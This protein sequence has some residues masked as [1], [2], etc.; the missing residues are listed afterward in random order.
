[1]VCEFMIT[2]SKMT[3]RFQQSEMDLEDYTKLVDQ[4]YGT[5]GS[6]MAAVG[7]S[8][9]L[10]TIAYAL[11]ADLLFVPLG[12]LL[13]TASIA[14]VAAFLAYKRNRTATPTR[15]E[16]RKWELHYAIPAIVWMFSLGVMAF[17]GITS[18]NSILH[19]F[20]TT[21]VIGTCGGMSSR[22]ASRPWIVMWQ[23]VAVLA[24]FSAGLLLNGNPYVS[25]LTAMVMFLALSIKSGT[26]YISD[27]LHEAIKNSRV[28]R[29]TAG[30]L[31]TAM[32]NMSQGLLMFDSA[33]TLV[34]HN[35]QFMEM[36]GVPL[37][38]FIDGK[39]T[40]R[41]I[42]VATCQA[43]DGGPVQPIE[44]TYAR[45]K[46]AML[47]RSP[48][49]IKI[50]RNNGFVYEFVI[51]PKDDGGCVVRVQDITEAER[52][53][54]QIAKMAH[55][56]DLTGM[57]NRALF[58]DRIEESFANLATGGAQFA[59]LS[60]DL[61]QFKEVNDTLGH[62]VGDR[63]LV[64]VA[65]RLRK[66]VRSGDFVARLGGDEFVVIQFNSSKDEAQRLAERL[67]TTICERFVLEGQDLDIGASIGIAM[68]P[69]DGGDPEQLMKSAD[70]ALYCSK[71]NGR[72]TWRFFNADM[73]T[74]L[75]ERRELEKDL[76]K[77]I[78]RDELVVFFQPIVDSKTRLVVTC[79]ALVRWKH[80]T[81]GMIFP[82]IF[83]KIAEDTGMIVDLGGIVLR[84]ACQEAMK[85]PDHVRV[86]V[87]LS[88]VQFKRNVAIDQ[89]KEALLLSGL[90]A[91]RLEVEI[92]ESML[93]DENVQQAILQLKAYGIRMSLDDFGTGYSSFQYLLDFD[94]D[95]VKIDRSFV[96][97][98][99]IKKS[100]GMI[101]RIASWAGENDMNVVAEGVENHEQAS[102]L[103]DIGVHNLQGYLFSRPCP[104]EE[105]YDMM[106]N[107][108]ALPVR[109]KVV[110]A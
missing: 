93:A 21:M 106:R 99:S 27:T 39:T 20:V 19:L 92:T 74:K 17:F 59:L 95:E 35:A 75:R 64:E 5:V 1:M 9:F 96:N 76:R 109:L 18:S 31:K 91:N 63:L 36:F 80:P 94:F 100:E 105:L 103:R 73:D 54:Q 108:Q 30:L 53:S 7:A 43:A 101:S 65:H 110:A 61:D 68:A 37:S 4:L 46:T 47:D 3:G 33:E 85:W 10:S 56:D 90:P 29:I 16:M 38:S 81:K 70:L 102:K 32:N 48:Q 11:T 78:E 44:Q 49:S 72:R 88:Q 83:I 66:T 104:P 6:F 12:M 77:A 8:I 42:V 98:L 23:V 22:N 86:A 45:F 67:V 28:S 89:I 51:Q 107:T 26:G 52:H 97:K 25:A 62:Q 60:L 2:F 40:L 41:D 82:D 14:R 55:F 34:V 13:A 79:E 87:N 69:F 84:K 24:P 50:H 15:R 71:A 58:R 57:P